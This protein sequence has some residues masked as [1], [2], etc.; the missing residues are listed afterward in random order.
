M[1]NHYNIVDIGHNLFL[2]HRDR[3]GIVILLEQT[4]HIHRN[5][6]PN[7][8]C[9]MIATGMDRG[10]VVE[11]KDG[12]SLYNASISMD[13]IAGFLTGNEPRLIHCTVGQTRSPTIAII[14]K[15]MRGAT[16]EEAIGDIMAKTWIARGIVTNLC[17]NPLAD[18]FE[19][20][21]S[22]GII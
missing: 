4:L 11:Y 17:L 5:D 3:C 14:G 21:E 22:R 12:E 18:N 9:H 8:S 19:W 6:M 20:A 13:T 10:L 1:R 2:S 16:F 15:L 7:N